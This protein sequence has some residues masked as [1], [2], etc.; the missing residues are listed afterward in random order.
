M[1][2]SV[3]PGSGC[4]RIGSPPSK[5]FGLPN[6]NMCTSTLTTIEERMTVAAKKDPIPLPAEFWLLLILKRF[7]GW[8]K[9]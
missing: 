7:K 5:L 6:T 8:F 4:P 1:T 2:P 3:L 9:C